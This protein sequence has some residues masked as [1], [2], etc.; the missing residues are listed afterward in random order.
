MA[1]VFGLCTAFNIRFCR[2]RRQNRSSGGDESPGPTT[3]VVHAAPVLRLPTRGEV[4][5]LCPVSADGS[6]GTTVVLAEEMKAS[7]L[8]HS[9]A[10]G[11]G[12]GGGGGSGGG[13]GRTGSEA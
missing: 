5:S 1:A 3:V 13:G 7:N 6:A 2:L 12:G 11:G 4:V 10:S 8:L 9:S